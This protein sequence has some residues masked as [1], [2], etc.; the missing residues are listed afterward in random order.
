MGPINV[1]V[2]RETAKSAG[3]AGLQKYSSGVICQKRSEMLGGTCMEV[4]NSGAEER[5]K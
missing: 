4:E 2:T 5:E 1:H 3:K